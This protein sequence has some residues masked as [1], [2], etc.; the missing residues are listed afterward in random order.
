MDVSLFRLNYTHIDVCKERGEVL[1]SRIKD[2]TFCGLASWTKNDVRE[3]NEELIDLGISAD[4][5][6]SP[7]H[8]EKYIDL[9]TDVY[10]GDPDVDLPDHADMVYNIPYDKSDVVNT[11]FRMYANS[12]LKRV[13]IEYLKNSI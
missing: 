5:V 11:Q 1:A 8:D 3:V 9:T 12:L 13:K 2:N 10:V 6:Y 4:I 7:M